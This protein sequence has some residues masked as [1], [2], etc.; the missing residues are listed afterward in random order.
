MMLREAKL[1]G[2]VLITLLHFSFLS[3][4]AASENQTCRPSSC[5]DIQNISIPFRLKGDPLGCGH[6][7]PAYELSSSCW[8][9]EEQ[10]FLLPLY[11]LTRNDLYR[12][13]YADELDTVV[14]MNC[15]RPIFDQYYIP[16]VPCNRTDDTFSSSQPYAYALAGRYKQS[17]A[18]FQA[19]ICKKSCLWGSSFHFYLR[20]HECKAKHGW[21]MPNFSNN[22]IQCL[23]DDKRNLDTLRSPYTTQVLLITGFNH[24]GRKD[25]LES[26]GYSGT[27][28]IGMALIVPSV[29]FH[30]LQIELSIIILLIFNV[31]SSF[32]LL[33]GAWFLENTGNTSKFQFLLRCRMNMI[34]ILF[35][36]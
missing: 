2:V 5:G 30:D 12:Y 1:A 22:T 15:A 17:P 11:S 18:I 10:L 28:G 21:C 35:I 31:V 14:L 8:A 33:S 9:R 23:G 6:P 27:V 26:S 25:A 20:C 7:D 16:I 13:E 19:Q 4:C 32:S 29:I 36:I 3:F 34:T 24:S